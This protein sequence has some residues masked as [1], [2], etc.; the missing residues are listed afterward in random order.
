VKKESFG[1]A[2]RG[3]IENQREIKAKLK[4]DTKRTKRIKK[5]EG[6]GGKRKTAQK[7]GKRSV[8]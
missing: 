8:G 2:E 1:E 7:G 4:P 5:G 6:R 3:V